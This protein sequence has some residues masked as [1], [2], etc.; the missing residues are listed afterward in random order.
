MDESSLSLAAQTLIFDL[1]NRCTAHRHSGGA[2]C[3]VMP[4]PGDPKPST[5]GQ[6]DDVFVQELMSNGLI[7]EK[8]N[9]ACALTRTGREYYEKH[10]KNRT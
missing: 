6:T 7:E 10:L 2:P 3:I 1:A 9:G 4:R 5:F 8:D